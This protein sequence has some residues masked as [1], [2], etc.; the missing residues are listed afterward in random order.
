[1]LVAR[2]DDDDD[3]DTFLFIFLYPVSGWFG[4][5]GISTLNSYLIINP[6]YIFERIEHSGIG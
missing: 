5:Y 2:H 4:I 1:M 6:L 3:D